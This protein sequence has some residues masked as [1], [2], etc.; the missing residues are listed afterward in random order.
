ML[1]DF[2]AIEAFVRG[3]AMPFNGCIAMPIIKNSPGRFLWYLF[4]SITFYSAYV[5]V[6]R[7]FFL[8][9]PIYL[10]ISTGLRSLFQNL[11]IYPINVLILTF[12][13]LPLYSYYLEVYLTLIQIKLL[14]GRYW[15]SVDCRFLFESLLI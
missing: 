9:H 11:I 4:F 14:I 6:L 2:S 12:Q 13:G 1:A 3:I 15:R 8:P 7:R 10:Q 5:P